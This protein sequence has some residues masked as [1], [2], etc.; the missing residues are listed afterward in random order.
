M[1]FALLI[2]MIALSIPVVAIIVGG[3]NK[4]AKWRLEE[5]QLR[6]G[7]GVEAE[8]LDELRS[9]LDQVRAELG[10]MHERLDFTERLLTQ[11]RDREGLP[12]A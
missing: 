11:S 3:I 4:R 12:P 6:M 1:D 8:E 9:E 2:P 10:E 5:A 7:G